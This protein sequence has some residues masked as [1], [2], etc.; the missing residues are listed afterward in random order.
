MLVNHFAAGLQL[1]VQRQASDILSVITL[2]VVLSLIDLPEPTAQFSPRTASEV[3]G[4][5][6]EII[7]SI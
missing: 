5:E 4:A 1:L 3:G 6:S 7:G 2:Q